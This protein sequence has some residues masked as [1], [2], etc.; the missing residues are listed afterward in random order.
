[1]KKDI[2][3]KERRRKKFEPI[4]RAMMLTM[5][6]AKV[7][8]EMRILKNHGVKKIPKKGVRKY[9]ITQLKKNFPHATPGALNDAANQIINI[10]IQRTNLK[11]FI[12]P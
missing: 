2:S 11:R 10:I 8:A 9:I 3:Q 5:I 4:G 6:T 12:G 7:I 1:M